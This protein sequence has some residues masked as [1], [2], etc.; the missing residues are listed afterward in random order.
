MSVSKSIPVVFEHFDVPENAE[1]AFKVFRQERCRLTDDVFE[2]LMF[3][4]CNQ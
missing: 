1:G 2:T 4:K 3:I